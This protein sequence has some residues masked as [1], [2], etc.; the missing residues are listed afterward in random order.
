VGAALVEIVE[1]RR[2]CRSLTDLD[3]RLP[4][5]L[6]GRC[7]QL[8]RVLTGGRVRAGDPVEIISNLSG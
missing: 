6:A 4:K 5:R 7:G 8:G 1:P 2:P 3:F